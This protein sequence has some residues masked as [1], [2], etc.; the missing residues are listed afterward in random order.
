MTLEESG[1]TTP[2]NGSDDGSYTTPSLVTLPSTSKGTSKSGVNGSQMTTASPSSLTPSAGRT[3]STGKGSKSSSTARPSTGKGSGTT[4]KVLGITST[5]SL[6]STT[7]SAPEVTT[8]CLPETTTVFTYT[9][10]D[11]L[12]LSKE[13]RASLRD[14]CWET[15]FGQELAKILVMD[16]LIAIMTTIVF[17]YGRAVFVRY[18]NDCSCIF[19][20]LETQFPGYAD[21]QIA[22]N[23]LA[24]VNNQANIW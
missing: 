6:I 9:A 19:W 1:L 5:T 4:G 18:C 14:L 21:F 12:K 7:T 17:D 22:E 15:M 10:D 23:I 20:D 8:Q 11:L 16:T 3:K 2:M 13:E 24:L